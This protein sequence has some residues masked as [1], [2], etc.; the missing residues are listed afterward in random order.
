M[1]SKEKRGGGEI[2]SASK[3]FYGQH[4]SLAGV[5]VQWYIKYRLYRIRISRYIPAVFLLT[6]LLASTPVRAGTWFFFLFIVSLH[7]GVSHEDFNWNFTDA[8]VMK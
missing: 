8:S 4:L 1:K 7:A 5:F 2:I 6:Y 3:A